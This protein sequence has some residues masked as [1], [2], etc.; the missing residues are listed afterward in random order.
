M[1]AGTRAV[2][3]SDCVS[4]ARSAR[5]ACAFAL[6]AIT[7]VANSASALAIIAFV[8]TRHWISRWSRDPQR[9]HSAFYES[10]NPANPANAIELRDALPVA[11][12]APAPDASPL[13][14][15]ALRTVWIK[16]SRR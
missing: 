9:R 1:P 11:A 7:A 8:I 15:N 12:R 2:T 4:P 5:T 13:G 14:N 16:C 10:S 3:L 6:R